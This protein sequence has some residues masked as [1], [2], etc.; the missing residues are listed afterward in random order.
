MY[1]VNAALPP[2]APR[3]HFNPNPPPSNHYALNTEIL[4]PPVKPI[5]SHNGR[6]NAPTDVFNKNGRFAQ[7][8]ET[9]NGNI[10][11]CMCIYPNNE[12]YVKLDDNRDTIDRQLFLSSNINLLHDGHNFETMIVTFQKEDGL[13]HDTDDDEYQ[14]TT[15]QLSK[16]NPTLTATL[17][18]AKSPTTTST[19]MT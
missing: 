13:D 12:I 9:I 18:K 11:D 8:S 4:Q 10:V 19:P 3:V 6:F 16:T 7:F 2:L 5:F 14:T 17:R 1:Q 15:A